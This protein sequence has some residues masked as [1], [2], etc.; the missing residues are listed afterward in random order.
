MFQ[1]TSA[2]TPDEYIEALEEPRRG[3]IRRLDEMIRRVAP[4]LERHIQSGMLAY[5]SYHYRYATGREGDWF[6]I[7]LASRKGYISL[8]YGEQR[9]RV[10][11]RVL[12]GAPAQGRY[13][14][15]LRPHQAAGG[16]G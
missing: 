7:G 9:R 10:S 4:D 13:R 16:R 15:E 2:T 5:G 3:Q 8:R 11:G 12:Q 6:P 14:S 1:A